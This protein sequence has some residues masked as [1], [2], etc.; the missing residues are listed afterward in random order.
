MKPHTER[1][2]NFKNSIELLS[3]T[4]SDAVTLYTKTRN[5]IECY[6]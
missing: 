5:F 4:L 6:W 3:V 1:E 2:K